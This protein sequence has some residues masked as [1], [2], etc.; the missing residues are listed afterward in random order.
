MASG[1][2]A[3]L[4][5]LAGGIIVAGCLAPVA[6]NPAASSVTPPAT[7]APSSRTPNPNE[8]ARQSRPPSPSVEPTPSVVPVPT[9][10]PGATPTPAPTPAPL[11]ELQALIPI[12]V[13]GGGASPQVVRGEDVVANGDAQAMAFSRMLDRLGATP[14]EFEGAASSCCSGTLAVFDMRVRGVSPEQLAEA[15][16]AASKEIDPGVRVATRTVAHT[17]V[18]RLRYPAGSGR[19]DVHL[20]VLRGVVFAFS[21]PADQQAN[22]DAT[23]AFMRRP[24]LDQLLPGMIGG[25]PTQRVSSPASGLIRGGDMCSFVCPGEG[26]ALA[27][28]VG[29]PV[30][31]IDFAYAASQ[32]A[33]V[34]VIAFRVPGA[35]SSE[36]LS[37]RIASFRQGEPPFGREKRVIGGKTVTW[38]AYSPF[39][40]SV[41]EREYLYARDHVLYSIRPAV[42]E[43]PPSASVVEAIAA[44]P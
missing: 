20:A 16:V 42:D 10:A 29:V 11:T 4:A 13:N 3:A 38:V 5:L 37:A 15:W 31:Q 41:F 26:D 7:V 18:Q 25:Q 43:G 23:I 6:T 2:R 30:E 32:T 35:S 39:P 36:L 40:D 34:L 19:Q 21:G 24:A 44:L 17:T 12:L 33:G 8:L 28:N 1:S 22:V 9:L 14:D 27:R